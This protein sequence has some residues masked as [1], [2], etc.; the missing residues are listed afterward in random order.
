MRDGKFCLYMHGCFEN[1]GKLDYMKNITS[2]SMIG[3]V[4]LTCVSTVGEM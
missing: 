1:P 4:G 3:S 2:F